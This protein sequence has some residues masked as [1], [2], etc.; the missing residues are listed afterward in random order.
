VHLV[1]G[2]KQAAGDATAHD[3]E[4][5]EAHARHVPHVDASGQVVQN[6]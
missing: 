1:T 4:T 2:G 3:A 6:R 5:D